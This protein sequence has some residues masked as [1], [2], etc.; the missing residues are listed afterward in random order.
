MSAK[1][2][3][4][5]KALPWILLIGGIIGYICSFIIMW[6][7]VKLAANPNFV[8]SCN[9][10]PI[11]SCGGV[12]QSAQ[13][14]VF[15]FPNPFIGLGAFP[16][17]AVVG[18]AML[19]GA[20]FKRWFWLTF[21]SGYTLGLIFAYWL[22]F[23]SVYRIH[24]LCPYCLGID[25]VMTITFWYLTLYNIDQ[26]HIRLPTGKTQKVYK[27]IRRHHLDLLVLWFLIVIALILKHFW[28]YYGRYF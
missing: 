18:G 21:Q 25:V 1:N 23:E 14:H 2:W 11:I 17:V 4:L 12:M 26:K 10:N 27:W 3:N 16:V 7:K 5:Q 22:L 24:A 6:D 8:P 19:A 20:R 13:A 28:Y 15:G 9:L